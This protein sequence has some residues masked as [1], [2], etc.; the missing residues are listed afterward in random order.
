[1]TIRSDFFAASES[2]AIR[3]VCENGFSRYIGFAVQV[4][5]LRKQRC[6]PGSIV[7]SKSGA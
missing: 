6:E 5:R 1:M 4:R 3:G 7:L 2:H